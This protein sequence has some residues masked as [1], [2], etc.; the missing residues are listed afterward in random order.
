MVI[1]LT[2]ETA[3]VAIDQWFGH[4]HD[5]SAPL[6]A[7]PMMIILTGAGAWFSLLFLRGV[8]PVDRGVPARA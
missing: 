6:A 3:G 5:A 1:M 2:L 8:R 4:L 7:V